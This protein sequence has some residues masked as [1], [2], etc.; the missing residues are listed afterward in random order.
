MLDAQHTRGTV[1]RIAD[2]FDVRLSVK[3][4][5]EVGADVRSLIS[6]SSTNRASTR[7]A[8]WRC[9]RR[10]QLRRRPHRGLPLRRDR[11]PQCLPHGPPMHP[12][13]VSQRPD[14]QTIT[15]MISTY[16][17][18]QLLPRPRHLRPSRSPSEHGEPSGWGQIRPDDG[19]NPPRHSGDQTDTASREHLCVMQ[20]PLAA[21]LSKIVP[22]TPPCGPQVSIEELVSASPSLMDLNV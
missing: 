14:R 1:G 2:Y 3:D 10:V 16:R 5:P 13:P 4:H 6:C 19:W 17:L 9:L 18:E 20:S 12:V 11:V 22:R 7:R 15:S 21:G 8:V